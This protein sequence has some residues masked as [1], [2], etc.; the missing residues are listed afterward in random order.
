MVPSTTGN[1]SVC[2]VIFVIRIR[3]IELIVLGKEKL[4]ESRLLLVSAETR[5]ISGP[6][7]ILRSTTERLG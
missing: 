4:K 5:R 1:I 2:G 6:S 3:L 7:N